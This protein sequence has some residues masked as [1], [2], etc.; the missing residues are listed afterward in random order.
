MLTTAT[1]TNMPSLRI[2]KA[3]ATRAECRRVYDNHNLPARDITVTVDGVVW[4][5]ES[6]HALNRFGWGRWEHCERSAG[7]CDPMRQRRDP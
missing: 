5:R 1:P 7:A 6:W 3:A 2:L 4:R